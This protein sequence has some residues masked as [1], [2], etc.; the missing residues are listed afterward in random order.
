MGQ[1]LFPGLL[2]RGAGG[3][4]EGVWWVKHRGWNAVVPGGMKWSHWRYSSSI[5]GPHEGLARPRGTGKLGGVD[6]A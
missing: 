3:F 4:R 2:A 5:A 1:G 6:G